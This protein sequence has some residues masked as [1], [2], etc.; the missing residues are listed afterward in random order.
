MSLLIAAFLLHQILNA[1]LH[2]GNFARSVSRLIRS[3]FGTKSDQREGSLRGQQLTQS[4]H[5]GV[6]CQK[7]RGLT[8]HRRESPRFITP[9]ITSAKQTRAAANPSARMM[10]MD[11]QGMRATR[12]CYHVTSAGEANRQTKLRL[13]IFAGKAQLQS[14]TGSRPQASVAESSKT[15]AGKCKGRYNEFSKFPLSR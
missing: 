3:V 10:A 7:R 12:R 1:G 4:R 6:R 15:P 8:N 11:F 13:A 2:A 9:V 14:I 5:S